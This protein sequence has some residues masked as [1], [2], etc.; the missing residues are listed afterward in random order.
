MEMLEFWLDDQ[1]AIGFISMIG[2]IVMMVIFGL[3]KISEGRELGHH[4]ISVSL[5]IVQFL[6]QSLRFCLLFFIAVENSRAVLSTNV[7]ALAVEGRRIV[8][9]EENSQEII[10]RD[11]T[12]IIFDSDGFSMTVLP[13]LTASYVGSSVRPPV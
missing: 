13:V 1:L 10:V 3:I 9:V 8:G 2:I 6:D 11:D 7:I 12:R 5:R 4:R